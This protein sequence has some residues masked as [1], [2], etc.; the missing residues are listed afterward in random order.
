LDNIPANI[1]PICP[2]DEYAISDFK[3][4][5]RKQIN[6]VATAPVKHSLINMEDV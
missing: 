3:S 2:T 6:L 4:G 5:W 1:N